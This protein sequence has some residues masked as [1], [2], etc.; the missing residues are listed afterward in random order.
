MQTRTIRG[1]NFTFKAPADMPDCQDLP[2]RLERSNG[3]M[4]HT[5]SA[6]Y[7]TPDE[8]ALLNAGEPVVLTIWGNGMPPVLLWV[9]KS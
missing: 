2:V 1:A 6:W 7:P 5:S 4:L 9:D 3:E 8:L